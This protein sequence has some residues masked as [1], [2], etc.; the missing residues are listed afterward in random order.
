MNSYRLV[1]D[2]RVIRT[3]AVHGLSPEDAL[4]RSDISAASH[5]DRLANCYSR[6]RMLHT[7]ET[8]FASVTVT[9]PDGRSLDPWVDLF[10]PMLAHLLCAMDV[11]YDFFL[12]DADDRVGIETT[13]VADVPDRRLFQRQMQWTASRF[14]ELS[15]SVLRLQRS[16]TVFTH[17]FP[18]TPCFTVARRPLENACESCLFPCNRHAENH[19]FEVHALPRK[20]FSILECGQAT[21]CI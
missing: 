3:L 12:D 7:L 9:A 17:L 20:R 15:A 21:A 18:P 1:E 2:E 6:G 13:P 14:P 4:H 8:V 16:D 19:A 10:I 11:Y 5:K